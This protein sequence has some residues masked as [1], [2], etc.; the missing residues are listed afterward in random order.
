MDTKRLPLEA[1]PESTGLA[2]RDVSFTSRVDRILL[3]GWFFPGDKEQVVVIVHGGYQNRVDENV[4]TLGLTKELVS[5]GYNVLLF[6]LRGRG[7]SEGKGQTLSYIDEDIGGAVDFLQ[8]T[9]YGQ[10]DVCIMG[11]CSGA[12]ASCIYA[13]R[14]DVG[15]LILDGCFID[16]PTM[17]VRQAEDVGIPGFLTRIFIPGIQFMTGAFYDYELINA[18]DVVGDVNC[19]ILFIRE[20][21]DEYTTWEDTL[22][23]YQASSNAENEVWEVNGSGHTQ[24]F[25]NHPEE[26]VEKVTGFLDKVM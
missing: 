3:K 1:N 22:E 10:D 12:V 5:S 23:L 15:A 25:L 20:E 11:F 18:I 26:Y 16:V 9:G 17:V 7:E 8:N 19:P 24:A 6:D 2:Y 14:N 4:G 13:S 21:Y